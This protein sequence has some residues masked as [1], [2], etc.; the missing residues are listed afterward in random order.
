LEV[1][2]QQS[3]GIAGRA[4]VVSFFGFFLGAAAA[5]DKYVKSKEPEFL[6]VRPDHALVYFARPEF[7]RMLSLSTF[8]VFVDTTPAGWLPQRSYLAAH[9]APGRRMVWGTARSSGQYFDF[10][11]GQ[12]YLLVLEESYGPPNNT[13]HE[14]SWAAGI[15]D[16]VRPFVAD[17]KLSYVSST[18]E[19]LAK[20]RG[21]AEKDFAKESKRNP[22]KGIR[23][24]AAAELPAVFET[25]WYR[26]GKRGFSLKAYDATGT[27]TVTSQIIEFKSNEK[28]L[29]IPVRD[30]Q[31]V[32]LA[33]VT[34][35]L[36]V[37]DPN[38]WGI[39]SFTASGATDVAAFRDGHGLGGGGDTER[40]YL[41]LRSV[42]TPP[43][44]NAAGLPGG[45]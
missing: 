12:T 32:S 35:D 15:P 1:A 16:A 27:L 4:L 45:L 34:S 41:T 11:A 23:S 39:V 13:L 20:L 19:A 22:D 36:N 9:V 3:P 44:E 6:E 2:M 37:A 29:L 5:D 43:P 30:I 18:E 24:P 33:K 21:E 14:T 42:A 17:K 10:L 31:S 40:I 25:V 8:K 26:P 28:T 38:L 7:M